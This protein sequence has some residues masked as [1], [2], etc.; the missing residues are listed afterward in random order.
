MGAPNR[1]SRASQYANDAQNAADN[2]DLADA[3]NGE[4]QAKSLYNY[5]TTANNNAWAAD[6][7]ENDAFG[8]GLATF[9]A[10]AEQADAISAE[11]SNYNTAVFDAAMADNA[12]LQNPTP[13]NQDAAA[14]ADAALQQAQSAYFQT[15]FNNSLPVVTCPNCKQ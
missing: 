5:S 12:A 6:A 1:G 14:A 3:Q 13:E 9:A 2:N 4:I 15:L 8:S 11:A 10:G 7:N